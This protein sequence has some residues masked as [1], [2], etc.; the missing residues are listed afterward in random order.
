MACARGR[1]SGCAK[2]RPETEIAENGAWERPND[3][4]SENENENGNGASVTA[5]DAKGGVEKKREEGEIFSQI[6]VRRYE[7]DETHVAVA[8]FTLFRFPVIPTATASAS[9]C[10]GRFQDQRRVCNYEKAYRNHVYRGD[11]LCRGHGLYH[12]R[13]PCY[14]GGIPYPCRDH[15]RGQSRDLFLCQGRP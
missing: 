8:P 7:I 11:Y 4:G 13:G 3:G 15:D 10:D 2:S 1:V 5:C 6:E 14:R 9:N 12:G